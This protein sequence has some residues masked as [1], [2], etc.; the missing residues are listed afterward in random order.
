MAAPLD[1]GKPVVWLRTVAGTALAGAD[2][3]RD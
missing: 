3:T 2:G 1:E